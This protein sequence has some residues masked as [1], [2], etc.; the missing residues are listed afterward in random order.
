MHLKLIFKETITI[1]L[2]NFKYNM[3]IFNFILITLIGTVF[4]LVE[5]LHNETVELQINPC[6]EN[7]IDSGTYLGCCSGCI[8]LDPT[9]THI[10]LD[11]FRDCELT[12]HL[13]IPDSVISID[14]HAFY[15]TGLTSLSLSNTLTSIGYEAFSQCSQLSGAL[16]VPN[17]VISI[18]DYAFYN[19]GLTSLK[20]GAGLTTIGYAAFAN[21][22]RLSGAL[23][24]PNSLTSIA[25]FA[26]QN[27]ALTSLTLGTSLATIESYAFSYCY[28]LSGA[29]KIPNSVTSIGAYA[30]ANTGLSSLVLGTALT[31]IG[32]SAFE[33]C[34]RLT[35]SLAIPNSVSTIGSSSFL[36][37]GFTSLTIGTDPTACKLTSI[38]TSAFSY[39]Y[40]LT[41]RLVIPDSVTS[42]NAYAFA[43]TAV[44][45]LTLGTGI[46]DIAA[47]AFAEILTLSS[48]DIDAVSIT[49][50]APDA[51]AGSCSPSVRYSFADTGMKAQY[52]HLVSKAGCMMH[53]GIYKSL[54]STA[55]RGMGSSLPVPGAVPGVF[56]DPKT[57]VKTRPKPPID[58]QHQY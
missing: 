22:Y 26:F 39:C 13:V 51:F 44:T 8:T 52:E 9:L 19:T 31:S 58:A 25:A 7:C 46:T 41:G 38:G 3:V 45:S 24:I 23:T 32:N 30:F 29:L 37:T 10:Y 35:G 18:N 49:S 47:F 57:K 54:A 15:S 36:Q 56:L 42:I 2:I 40:Q 4:V 1:K 33:N 11:A 14:D 34:Y 53:S 17:S 27:A 21:G 5:S 55:E 28:Q 20:L 48:I 6:T 43:N 50:F 12:G 16:I